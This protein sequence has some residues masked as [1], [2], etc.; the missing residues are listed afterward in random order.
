VTSSD[1]VTWSDVKRIP[2][3]AVTST[4]DHFLPGVGVDRATSGANTHV[5]VTYYFYPDT[6]C[7]FATCDLS[8]GY[9]S[10]A[11]GGSSWS[12]PT[13]L[14]GP[15]E[16]SWLPDT[17]QGRMVGDY[18]STSIGSDGLAH[19][20]FAVAAD[21]QGAGSDCATKTPNCDQALYSPATGLAATGGAVTA[22]DPVLFAGSVGR[23]QSAFKRR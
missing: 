18:I 16:M 8:V 3:D 12:T 22:S 2:I 6:D 21:P 23:G 17:S 15:M 9:I 13:Q 10:S 20:A 11:N 1:G 14:A 19:P 4:V 7:T 5:G